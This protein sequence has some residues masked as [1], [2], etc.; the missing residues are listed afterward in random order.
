MSRRSRNSPRETAAATARD[1][2]ENRWRL[3]LLEYILLG[4][5]VLGIAITLAMALL[6]P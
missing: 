4:L 5:I 3:G 2:A 1:P 6:N